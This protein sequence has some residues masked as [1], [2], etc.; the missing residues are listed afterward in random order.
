VLG[1]GA[2]IVTNKR[3]IEADKFFKGLYETALE[4]GE[5]TPTATAAITIS[6]R[7]T[8]PAR[9]KPM[10]IAHALTCAS[11]RQTSLSDCPER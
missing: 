6:G 4:P 3:K 10:A 5:R 2:T 1:L 9:W 8:S 11:P 7:P